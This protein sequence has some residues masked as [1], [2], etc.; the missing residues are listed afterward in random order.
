MNPTARFTY[1]LST[2]CQLLPRLMFCLLLLG[3]APVLL[4]SS[5]SAQP[6]N[7]ATTYD[8]DSDSSIL[9]IYVGRAGPLARMGHNHVVHSREL[10]GEV[11]L[12]ATATDSSATFTVPVSSLVVDEQSERDR[13]GEGFESQPDASAIEGTRGNM[14]SEAVLNAEAYPTVAISATPISIDG[15]TW[16]LAI[17][18]EI[19]GNTVDLEIPAQV[20]SSAETLSAQASFTLQHEDLGLTAFSALGGAMR[21]AEAIDFELQVSATARN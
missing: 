8:I 2:R 1:S 12:A 7:T 19:S 16:L 15:S 14:L 3:S 11:M 4:L 6:G 5:A 10:T 21:V 9:R 17:Q 20:Q 13:A 18:L